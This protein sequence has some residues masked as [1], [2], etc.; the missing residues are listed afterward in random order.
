MKILKFKTTPNGSV[1]LQNLFAPIGKIRES[2]LTTYKI[3]KIPDEMPVSLVLKR[4]NESCTF[5]AENAGRFVYDFNELGHGAIL[6][7]F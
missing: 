4:L 7:P 6:S 3:I 5:R 1:V 2:G